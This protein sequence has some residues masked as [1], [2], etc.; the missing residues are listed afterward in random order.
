MPNPTDHYGRMLTEY[1]SHTCGKEYA[2]PVS[3]SDLLLDKNWGG[4]GTEPEG[5]GTQSLHCLDA[6]PTEP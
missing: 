1:L 2:Q 5:F 6:S 3:I 4:S